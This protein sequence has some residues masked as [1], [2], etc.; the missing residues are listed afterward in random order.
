MQPY[1][2]YADYVAL[3]DTDLDPARIG[4][5]LARASRDIR[6][7]LRIAC[8]DADETDPDTLADLCD[9][10]CAM[11]H[12]AIG[13]DTAE[14]APP[15]P[16]GASQFSQGA[17]SYTRSATLANPYGDLFMTESERR[18]LGIGLPRATVVSPYQREVVT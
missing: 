2:T 11:V 18:K 6:S 5:L 8:V 1:A 12:R 14:D 3:Y 17:G 15:I 9:V 16:F 13:D 10:A 4:A 7:E